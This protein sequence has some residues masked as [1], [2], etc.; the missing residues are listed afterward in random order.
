MAVISLDSISIGFRG[1]NLLD[2][3]SAKVELG[4][5][6]GLLG[7]NGAGKTTLL[8]M[9]AGELAPDHGEIQVPSTVSVR[10][11]VQDVPQDESGT[12]EEMVRA[13]VSKEL[14]SDPALAWEADHSV[15][16]TLSDMQLD[17]GLDFGSLSS[18]MKRRV[19]L[20]R[21]IVSQ[22]DVLLLDEP[23]NHLDVESILWLED[24]L[25]RWSKTLIF[26]THDRS[27]LQALASRIWEIDRGQLFDWTCDYGTFLK[28]KEQALEAE[29]KQNALFD[30]RLA[31]EE[32]WIRQ[33]I[34]ARRTRNEGRVRR[35]KD[36]RVQ[37]Q[38]RQKQVG[39]AKLSVQEA[40]RSGMLVADVKDVS[41]A[42]GERKIVESF[43]T[44]IMRGDKI[45]LIGPNGAGKSTLLKLLLGQLEPDSG[46]VRLGTKLQIAYFDQLRD[47]LDPEQTVQ[48]NVGEGSDQLTIG[49]AKKHVLGYLQDYLFT[50]ERARTKVKFLSGGERN[51]ALLAKLM[52]K[53]A[54]VLILDEPTND[55]DAETLELLEEVLVS[56]EGTLLL[57]SHDRTFLNNVV[58]S[59][60]VFEDDNVRQYVGGYDDWREA[61]ERRK[62]TEDSQAVKSKANVQS[63]KPRELDAKPVETTANSTS[64][65]K[66]LSYKEQRELDAIPEKI[67]V[68]ESQIAELHSLMAAPEYYQNGGDQVATDAAKL[69]KL[70]N[71]LADLYVR[72]EELEN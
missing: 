42:Y 13:G 1:P 66:K 39:T 65:V 12:I 72:W 55:L 49:S 58:T 7:R 15:E 22:P 68:A 52:T 30:K 11:L 23:T 9:L 4:D 19:L 36:M 69:K 40:E 34:K 67:E 5:R 21:S 33:G 20:A 32:A 26:I 31:E 56:F 46:N 57:V 43:S 71:E 54:N 28:R 45:G 37:R 29:E 35:L 53:P 47:T 64:P 18:G 8:K 62:T 44:T 50:P 27:F 61:V 48:E 51:R 70:Q 25:S 6:I 10:R 2:E 16:R 41:F 38:Q 3:V 24:F 17:G 63:T 14:L 59:T 60:L